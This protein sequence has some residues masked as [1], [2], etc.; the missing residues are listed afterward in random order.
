VLIETR[1]PAPLVPLGVFRRRA[2]VGANLVA[3]TLTA[4]TGAAAVLSTS[5]LQQVLD[6][7]PTATGF[8]LLPFSLCVVAGAGLG[9]ALIARFGAGP[10]AACG[11][12]GVCAG[13]L[14]FS[15]ISTHAGIPYLLAGLALSGGCLGWASVAA[16]GA[17]TA[18][19]RDGEAG[20]VAGLLNT[21][22][23]LGTSIGIAAL[24]T[25]AAARTDTI[26][27][28]GIPRAASLVEGFQTAYLVASALAAAGVL[29]AAPLLARHAA[30]TRS[31][32]AG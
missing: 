5:H 30:A 19:A 2:L 9:P 1:V 28:D 27:R 22:T 31:S 11:L 24:T 23:Q 18:E 29:A 13:M 10:T 15:R 17:G 4:T 8:V 32:T 7:S 6:Q 12:L 3:L 21:A 26:A 25:I 16:T 14:L 20:M